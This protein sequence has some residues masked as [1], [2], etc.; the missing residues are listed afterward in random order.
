MSVR[1]KKLKNYIGAV[2]TVKIDLG[3]GPKKIQINKFSARCVS[4]AP[5]TH[6]VYF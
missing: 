5:S 1:V 3:A 6:L 4:H 2:K